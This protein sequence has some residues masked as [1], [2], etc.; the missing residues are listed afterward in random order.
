MENLPEIEIDL[1]RMA[2]ALIERGLMDKTFAEMTKDEIM[3]V[4]RIVSLATMTDI[5]F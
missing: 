4:C 1:P 2:Q 5:P 3:D